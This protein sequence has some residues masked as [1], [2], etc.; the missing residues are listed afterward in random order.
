MPRGRTCFTGKIKCGKCGSKCI[1]N[2]IAHSKTTIR[3]YYERWTCDGQ[4]KH[5][6]AYCD[7]KSLNED[8]LR[9]ATVA[10]LGDKANYEV[11]FIQEVDEVIL[12]DDKAIFDLKD[13][14]KLEWQRE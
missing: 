12:F 6:M 9:K 13:G 4:R 2:P 10:L 5:K 1:R 8:E 7:L 11:R 3:E 14:R